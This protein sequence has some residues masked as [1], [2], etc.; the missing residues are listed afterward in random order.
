MNDANNVND[1]NLA[2]VLRHLRE[3]VASC[4]RLITSCEEQLKLENQ[5]QKASFLASLANRVHL[6]EGGDK[7]FWA[8]PTYSDL[9]APQKVRLSPFADRDA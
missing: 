6:E 5:A 9:E 7:T 8:G 3:V 2:D 1:V 4:D